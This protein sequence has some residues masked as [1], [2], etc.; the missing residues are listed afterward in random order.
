MKL[1]VKSKG[2]TREHSNHTGGGAAL[3]GIGG[4]GSISEVDG[5]MMFGGKGDVTVGRIGIKGGRKELNRRKILA[6]VGAPID[7][8]PILGS[9]EAL[10]QVLQSKEMSIIG[11]FSKFCQSGDG[12]TNVKA[13][14][15]IS[16]ENFTQ[17][18]MVAEAIL[19]GEEQVGLGAFRRSRVGGEKSGEGFC[20]QW[21]AKSSG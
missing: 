1:G 14:Q 11:G 6:R 20:E 15:N 10:G 7:D 17:N 9:T 19:F 8:T 13:A 4:I 5:L 18:T 2:A 16:I 3:A 12:K 21:R